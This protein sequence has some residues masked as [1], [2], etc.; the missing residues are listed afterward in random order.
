MRR[1]RTDS[2][3]RNAHHQLVGLNRFHKQNQGAVDKVPLLTVTSLAVLAAF[4]ATAASCRSGVSFQPKPHGGRRPVTAHL[5][6]IVDR[7]KD[8]QVLLDHGRVIGLIA[9]PDGVLPT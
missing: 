2:K 8:R 7:P 4:P 6:E 5:N 9:V 3:S 1:L